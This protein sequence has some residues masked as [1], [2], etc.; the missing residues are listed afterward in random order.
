MQGGC[1]EAFDFVMQA[2][3]SKCKLFIIWIPADL[4][5]SVGWVFELLKRSHHHNQIA[6]TAICSSHWDEFKVKLRP[7]Y[8]F[9]CSARL[10]YLHSHTSLWYETN[11]QFY[12]CLTCTNNTLSSDVFLGEC[13]GKL[14]VG[15]PLAQI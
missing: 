9:C 10:F 11:R 7:S 13:I 2:V 6:A 14:L 3:K 4:I 1:S 5:I 8:S 15:H 12:N